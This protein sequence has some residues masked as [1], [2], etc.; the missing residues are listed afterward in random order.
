[1]RARRRL[2]L[3]PLVFAGMDA[4]AATEE[5][6]VTTR[7]REENLQEVPIAITAVTED[8]IQNAGIRS[9]QDLARLTPSIS[10]NESFSQNDVRVTIR[11]LT[12]TRG[13]SNVAYLVDGVDVTSET[14]GTN[15]GS[16][17][18]VNQRLLNDIERVEIVRGPQ[19]A[20]FG[21]AAFAGAISYVTK[22]PGDELEGRVGLDMAEYGKY[23]VN[24]AVSL[25]I[26]DTLAARL[27]GVYWSEDGY[28]NNAASGADVG[29]GDGRAFAGTLLF[30]P[31]DDL[32]IKARV[33][34][35]DDEYDIRPVA[36]ITDT[37]TLP[38][39]QD[40]I[41]KGVLSPST[42][43]PQVVPSIGSAEGLEVRAS[44]DVL[45]GGE[46]PGNSLEVLRGTLLAEW[47]LG[48]YV[49]SAF[50]GWTDAELTQRYD[51]DRQAEGVPDTILGHN[52]VD[53]R[54][55]TDQFS[56]ELRLASNWDGPVQA[57][58]GALYWTEDR[59]SQARNIIAT[60]S[61]VDSGNPFEPSCV[62][63][64]YFSWQDIYREVQANDP[65]TRIP[66]FANT[67][68]WS[69]YARLDWQVIESVRV[70]VEDRYVD[71]DFEAGI[72]VGSNCN[73]FVPDFAPNPLGCVLSPL[74]TGEVNTT[75]HTPKFTVEWQAWDD[76]LIYVSAA[77][78][79][80]PGGISLLAVAAPIPQPLESFV[81]EP[82]KMWAYE[83]GAKTSWFDRH[84][85]LNTAVF[86]Q[87]YT[88][89]QASSSVLLPGIGIPVGVVN[90]ASGAHVTGVELEFLWYT[91]VDGLSVSGGYTWLNAE[92]DDYLDKSRSATAIAIQGNCDR[93][94]EFNGAQN[95][96]IDY[97]GN[98]LEYAPEH[99]FAVQFSY[100]R[101][102]PGGLLEAFA[103]FDARYQDE[104]F[105]SVSNFTTQDSY[106]LADLRAGLQG[107]R[108]KLLAY[109]SNVFDDDT[110]R[111]S[112]GG[113]PDFAVGA[114]DKGLPTSPVFQTTATLPDPRVFG[115]RLS[116][117]F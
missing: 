114:V 1:M 5:I 111:T 65:L 97:S 80:K 44:E 62:T 86:Y 90:N 64:G 87:D 101:P 110:I 103:E 58:I 41:D 74:L 69:A 73:N 66:T 51:L 72:P 48:D 24:G 19:S 85:V 104:V 15:A 96:V 115:M 56:Q 50:T 71:E 23:E 39:P 98:D 13:R 47:R 8:V 43:E 40:A 95:C 14:T 54:D 4:L 27:N 46:Y 7:Y 9:V 25:P 17:L 94:V 31:T 60:C 78:G 29:G 37:V 28:Y 11:G 53:T 89:K 112:A 107:D 63:L 70:S 75:Y 77:K 45:T 12:N 52:D 108:W 36:R 6:V 32:K 21:R 33:T 82:E 26:S 91:P 49:L 30:R 93:T 92:Y 99:A 18:L 76:G 10:V 61:T 16:P 100:R 34:W 81:F 109:L 22:E 59:E 35:S 20:L 2:L 3:L 105:T 117:E 116:Y 68:H 88:D 84:L 106:W 67:D 79:E 57:T 113:N 83:A 55:D 102:L 38:I 42:P